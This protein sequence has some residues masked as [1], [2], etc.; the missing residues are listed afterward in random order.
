M[1]RLD[2]CPMHYASS[3]CFGCLGCWSVHVTSQYWGD[4]GAML[5]LKMMFNK[6]V[7]CTGKTFS[8]LV[9]VWGV[10]F[11][12]VVIE[13]MLT[14]NHWQLMIY[15]LYLI[16]WH[17]GMEFI[18]KG[19][20]LGWLQQTFGVTIVTSRPPVSQLSLGGKRIR[21]LKAVKCQSMGERASWDQ[22]LER[23]LASNSE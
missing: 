23:S 6:H 17:R 8:A 15:H 18:D 13:N 5:C 22:G 7:M 19:W 21:E 16:L 2:K 3:S 11:K 1:E 20:S 12:V 4:G 9:P 14:L 10:W